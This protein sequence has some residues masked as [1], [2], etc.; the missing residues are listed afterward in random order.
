MVASFSLNG[1]TKGILFK[2]PS[3]LFTVG[4]KQFII[5]AESLELRKP[6]V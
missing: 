4:F 5:Y 3:V 6:K 1:T 2:S